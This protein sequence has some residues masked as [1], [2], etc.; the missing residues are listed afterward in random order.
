MTARKRV[1][2]VVG[3]YCPTMTPD[4]H[5]A[6]ILCYELPAQGWDV[7]ILTP[8]TSFQRC[9]TVD[10]QDAVFF[11][12]KT[13]VHSATAWLPWAFRLAQMNGIGFRSLWPM[14][15][16]GHHLLKTKRFDLV[17]F[18]TTQFPLFILGPLW[19]AIDR[20]PYVLDFQDP[21][22]SR[23][24]KYVATS[25]RWK[26]IVSGWLARPLQRFAVGRA[27][28]IVA[29]SPRYLEELRTTYRGQAFPWLAPDRQAVVPFAGANVDIETA[30]RASGDPLPA[31]QHAACDATQPSAKLP[32]V[33]V[34]AGGIT[35]LKAW[36]A[37]CRAAI[38]VRNHNPSLIERFQ[39][40]LFGTTGDPAAADA[41]LLEQTGKALGLEGFVTEHPAQ[42][43]YFRSLTLAHR[44][45]GLVVLG[46]DDA[47]YTP[48]KL[49]NYLL[50]EQPV[51][52]VCHA[53]SPAAAFLRSHP[54]LAYLICFD[55]E[56]P[57]PAE[58][59][60]EVLEQYLQ[61]VAAGRRQARAAD[62]ADYLAPAMARAHAAL[63]DRCAKPGEP[64]NSSQGIAAQ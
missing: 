16:L 10:A 42:V 13:P 6:R 54:T 29:V 33:Y 57:C 35:R 15:R 47:S 37:L 11:D 31:A 45:A 17:Y 1:L 25:R 40:R 3:S 27:G 49:F 18:S 61:A 43:S 60:A 8:D 59:G 4:M 48:S 34:G 5:R 41:G 21:W 55:S 46:V 36:E 50:F 58:S 63:F 53:Q 38:L 56:Q 9:V 28:A 64:S 39:F 14:F 30:R 51:L 26:W 44:A 62:L 52:A 12:A 24:Q 2:I 19:H 20:V 23:K 7:E 22:Y 32:I